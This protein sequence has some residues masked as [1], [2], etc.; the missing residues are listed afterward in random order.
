MTQDENGVAVHFQWQQKT[1]RGS[2]TQDG[3]P[4]QMAA[5][6][7]PRPTRKQKPPSRQKCDRERW[8]RHQAHRKQ[9][10]R[11]AKRESSREPPLSEAPVVQVVSLKPPAACSQ[12]LRLNVDALVFTPNTV[13]KS[14]SRPFT[15]NDKPSEQS[16]SKS[17]TN[18]HITDNLVDTMSYSNKNDSDIVNIGIMILTY[19]SLDSKR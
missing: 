3:Q 16:N 7:Q 1:T 8:L 12:P 6:H 15:S 5:I 11:Q 19:P 4:G 2:S 17:K 14:T 13:V 10:S 9:A 18:E